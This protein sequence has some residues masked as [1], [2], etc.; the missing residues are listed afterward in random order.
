MESRAFPLPSESFEAR[1]AWYAACLS[2]VLAVVALLPSVP[3][4][5]L[6]LVAGTTLA[7]VLGPAYLRRAS[8]LASV[9]VTVGA[10]SLSTATV[11]WLSELPWETGISWSQAGGVGRP[12]AWLF[13]TTSL[14]FGVGVL[15]TGRLVV[16]EGYRRGNLGRRGYGWASLLPVIS[17]LGFA[18]VALFPVGGAPALAAAHNLASW[19]AL[20]S[21]W[22]GMLAT[23]WLRG[24]S[25]ALR[26]FSAVATVLV[27]GAWLPNGL[28]FMRL[29]EARPISMLAMELVVFPLCFVWFGW[30]ASEW[31]GDRN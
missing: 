14:F 15:A 16:Q 18:V 5:A 28:R 23:P 25:R 7:A 9:V 24:V 22:V 1:V 12:S 29:I 2:V 19:A 31:T 17:C 13:T 20:G 8:P 11:I 3:M 27:L 21:F 6:A 30:L 4:R 10:A 26:Y